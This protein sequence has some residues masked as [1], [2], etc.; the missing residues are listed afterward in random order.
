MPGPAT[1]AGS[2]V[3]G[4]L[5]GFLSGAQT[6]IS[7]RRQRAFDRQDAEDR[8]R[9][10]QFDAED[11]EIRRRVDARADAAALRAQEELEAELWGMGFVRGR[12]DP[13]ARAGA[14]AGDAFGGGRTPLTEREIFQGD[15]FGGGRTPLT[16]R[17][18]F[19]GGAVGGGRTPLTEREIFQDWGQPQNLIEDV[20]RLRSGVA[21]QLETPPQVSPSGV[22]F[23]P[24]NAPVGM[25]RVRPTAEAVE[26]FEAQQKAE[27]T[28][29]LNIAVGE[30]FGLPLEER[31][32]WLEGNPDVVGELLDR[33]LYDDVLSD[34]SG[35]SL[36]RVS[37]DGL[38]YNR[39]P[40]TGDLTPDLDADGNQRIDTR[41]TE[42]TAKQ[43]RDTLARQQDYAQDAWEQIRALDQDDFEVQD[44]GSWVQ[45]VAGF[46]A[47]RETMAQE[48]G[49]ES[50]AHVRDI[51][52][53]QVQ[54]TQLIKDVY[55]A[56]TIS[57]DVSDENKQ[58]AEDIIDDDLSDKE[59]FDL[60]N[61][62][63]N[64]PG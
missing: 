38:W 39:D 56:I 59:K 48:S 22:P 47:A 27:R 4:L 14:P 40:R 15:A 43:E 31:A 36:G 61:E 44:A 8:E 45:D 1:S 63:L 54:Y 30:V 51:L 58:V 10:R 50:V 62:I 25:T 37:Y 52:R 57:P 9:Q 55:E 24:Y 20:S 26:A 13:E 33:G 16:E 35:P 28:R 60:L 19:Q 2:A 5:E 23:D 21:D 49:F 12:G 64:R 18:I 42:A 3:G 11:R 46:N 53:E 29:E 32:A 7:Y 17:E 6:G 34:E 41:A